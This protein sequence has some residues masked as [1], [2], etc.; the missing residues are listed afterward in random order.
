[1]RHNQSFDILRYLFIFE[2]FVVG[3]FLQE[4][5]RF[6]EFHH[7]ELAHKDIIT[8]QLQAYQPQASEYNFTHLFV[9]R[10]HFRFQWSL[11]RDWL[12]LLATDQ[13]GH[14]YFLQPIGPH[15]HQSF[16]SE[17]LTWLQKE[18]TGGKAYIAR[19]D[20]CLVQEIADQP[21]LTI[22]QDRDYYDY[23]YKRKQLAYLRGRKYH[24]K[25]NHINR[26]LRNHKYQYVVLDRQNSAACRDVAVRWCQRHDCA[27]DADLIAEWQA[28]QQALKYF[29]QLRLSG[30]AI[31]VDGK[32]EAFTMG[33]L[34]NRNSM[35]IHFE[36]ARADI[37][38]LYQLINQQYCKRMPATIEY[39]N[40]EQDMGIEGLR[41]AKKS[42]HP[43]HMVKKYKVFLTP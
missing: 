31:T 23:V 26:F 7:I 10:H 12:L 22:Q 21:G 36:K 27:R 40:R 3:G 34:L 43:D 28:L 17:I 29:R 16:I 1:M 19:A 25:R 41:K 8:N 15:S 38:G 20:K 39:V 11:Y 32:I 9:W 14:R 2:R 42:Y 30:G 13:A 4:L 37:H 18:Q 5:P 24:A 33:E 35:V 6:P